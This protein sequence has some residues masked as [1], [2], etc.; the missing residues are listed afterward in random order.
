MQ[1]AP[2]LAAKVVPNMKRILKNLLPEP[3]ILRYHQFIAWLGALRYGFPAHSLYVIGVTGTKGKTSTANFIWS[4][5]ESGGIKTGMIST[6]NIRIRDR[7]VMNQY[8]MTMPGRWHIQRLMREMLRA[9]CQ[10]EDLSAPMATAIQRY[11]LRAEQDRA[12]R[13]L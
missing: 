6:A 10:F 5:L 7:E 11:I 1:S 3:L 4:C 13:S 8:H 12:N 2:L 9:G